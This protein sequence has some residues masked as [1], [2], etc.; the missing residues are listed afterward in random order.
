MVVARNV[1]IGTYARRAGFESEAIMLYRQLLG[2]D[3]QPTTDAY[4]A[5]LNSCAGP[6][7]LSQG[8]QIQ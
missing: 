7:F 8:E 4:V 1:M 5:A 3:P 2:A 6:A